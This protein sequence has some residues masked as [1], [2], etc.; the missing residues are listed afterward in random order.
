[1]RREGCL[2]PDL[3][4][5]IDGID[6]FPPRLIHKSGSTVDINLLRM[7]RAA[8]KANK[9]GKYF[10]SGDREFGHH[11]VSKPCCAKPK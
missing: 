11:R 6:Q 4:G 7:R 10:T 3:A 1:L 9:A 5:V 8:D 2:R